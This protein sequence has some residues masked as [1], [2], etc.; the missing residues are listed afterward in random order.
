MVEKLI[1]DKKVIKEVTNR[2]DKI[3]LIQFNLKN[4]RAWFKTESMLKRKAIAL[5]RVINL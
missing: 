5:S 3:L 2:S 1:K 4:K